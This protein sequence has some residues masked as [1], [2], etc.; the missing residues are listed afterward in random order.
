MEK[1][2]QSDSEYRDFIDKEFKQDGFKIIRDSEKIEFFKDK[3]YFTVLTVLREKPMTVKEITVKYN[4]KI[5]E[6]SKIFNWT[7]RE[8]TARLRTDKTLYRYIKDLVRTDF[9]VQAGQRVV[10]GRTIT[11]ALFARTA[12]LFFLDEEP[13]EWWESR[14]GEKTIEKIAEL[15][16]LYLDIPKPSTDCIKKLV[17]K[18]VKFNQ[19]EFFKVFEQGAEKASKV[20]Y[21][22]ERLEINRAV[23]IVNIILAIIKSDEYEQELRDCLGL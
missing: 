11:E 14:V 23:Q 2:N 18:I 5:E 6:K 8:R 1:T 3:N 19:K 9:I 16:E 13:I 7:E 10:L 22:S 15:M 21:S 12:V 20:V 4:Q 17:I